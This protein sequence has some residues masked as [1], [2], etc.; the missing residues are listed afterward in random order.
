MNRKHFVFN[1]VW[2]IFFII[3]H[4]PG[5]DL[6]FPNSH[7]VRRG[8]TILIS[9][10]IDMHEDTVHPTRLKWRPYN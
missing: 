3:E 5:V 4:M 2:L 9:V 8:T 7:N 6:I 1:P 10:L